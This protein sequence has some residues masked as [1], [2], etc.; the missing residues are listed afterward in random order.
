MP[1]W[2]TLILLPLSFALWCLGSSNRDDVIGLL[3]HM[4]AVGILMV[5]ILSGRPLPLELAG[6]A[7]A[8]LLPRARSTPIEPPLPGRNDVLI[9]FL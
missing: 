6:V 3:E 1:L 7:L 2:L 8:L 4:L 9:P 5:V